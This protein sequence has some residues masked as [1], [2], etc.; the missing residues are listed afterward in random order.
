MISGCNNTV[1]T[2]VCA[3]GI[4]LSRPKIE[5]QWGTR[6][7]ETEIGI[8]REGRGRDGNSP[9]P[10]T[11]VKLEEEEEEEERSRACVYLGRIIFIRK[12]VG[13]KRKGGGTGGY[14]NKTNGRRCYREGCFANLQ[15]FYSVCI[16]SKIIPL[17]ENSIS[18][19]LLI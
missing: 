13:I 6:Q 10:E 19:G 16:A 3:R 11:R 5:I 15:D 17:V 7:R 2:N 9:R 12:H 4:P 18:R 8:E 14:G 1:V